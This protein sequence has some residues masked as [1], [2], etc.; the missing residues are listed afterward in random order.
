MSNGPNAEGSQID[1]GNVPGNPL[2][3][4]R[5]SMIAHGFILDNE[6]GDERWV[7]GDDSPVSYG[8][9]RSV[10]AAMAVAIVIAVALV[11]LVTAAIITT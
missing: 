3:S 9:I 10:H 8:V 5:M 6:S 11:I 7:A 1:S 4:Y 2:R